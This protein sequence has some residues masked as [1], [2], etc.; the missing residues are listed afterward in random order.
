M[1]NPK[2]VR[3]GECFIRPIEKLPKG[4]RVKVNSYIIGHSESQHHHVLEG[5]ITVVEQPNMDANIFFELV[6]VGKVVH[7]KTVNRHNDLTLAPGKYEVIHKQEYDPFEKVMRD[8][9]D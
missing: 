2:Y 3:H 1:Q 6:N 5:E 7:Q 9:W 8:V 4:K